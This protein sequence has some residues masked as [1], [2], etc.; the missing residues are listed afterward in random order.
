MTTVIIRNNERIVDT[1][2]LLIGYILWI[3]GFMGSHRFYYGKQKTGTLWFFTG[4]LF[5]IGWIV[6]LFLLPKMDQEADMKYWDGPVQYPMAW[7]FLVF[8]GV[9]GIHKIYMEK[10]LIGVLYFLTGGFFFIGVIYDFWTL[11]DQI[12]EFNK[13]KRVERN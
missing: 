10:Y 1:H 3:F 8:L 11:N 7:I 4:G 2:S 5:G 12:N 9:F 13:S 6:D